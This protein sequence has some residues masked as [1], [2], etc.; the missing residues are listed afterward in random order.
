[1]LCSVSEQ[2]FF[3]FP[4]WKHERIFL[5]YRRNQAPKGKSHRIV[6][7][8]EVFDPQNDHL[9]PLAI[10]QLHISTSLPITEVSAPRSQNT[11][12]SYVCLSS[13]GHSGFFCILLFIPK[14]YFPWR[15]DS[16]LGV[17][18]SQLLGML[19]LLFGLHYFS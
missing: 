9:E 7:L 13:L 1:M 12:Y 4:C 16:G 2:F 11:L 18:F 5:W 10:C 14:E 3:P 17:L 19:I 15:Q 8:L 6:G